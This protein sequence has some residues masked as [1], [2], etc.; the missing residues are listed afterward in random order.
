MLDKPNLS[1][2]RVEDFKHIHAS[3][4]IKTSNIVVDWVTSPSSSEFSVSVLGLDSYC[5]D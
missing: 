3:V 2:I 5:P 4:R 1:M